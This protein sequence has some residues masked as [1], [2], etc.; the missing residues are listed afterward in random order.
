MT[1][2]ATN[3]RN[4]LLF[5]CNASE[6]S[7]SFSISSAVDAWIAKLYCVS[8][9]SFLWI[10]LLD[11]S[12]RMFFLDLTFT[13]SDWRCFSLSEYF[14]TF[15]RLNEWIGL[16]KVVR[17]TTNISSRGLLSAFSTERGRGMILDIILLNGPTILLMRKL[18]DSLDLNWSETSYSTS[19][20]TNEV[21]MW[22]NQT[23]CYA[24]LLANVVMLAIFGT[25][26]PS[27]RGCCTYATSYVQI[28]LKYVHARVIAYV[29]AYFTAYVS[30]YA[31]SSHRII[32]I[33]ATLQLTT[34]C[35]QSYLSYVSWR[36]RAVCRVESCWKD[37]TEL[38]LVIVL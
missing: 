4:L 11:W 14:G 10:L 33:S 30:A 18:K 28:K 25:L 22:R 6:A 19:A 29:I 5:F 20:I 21:E 36:F 13:P 34:L 23:E 12:A 27:V 24:M 1:G 16:A 7:C 31:S 8:F 26:Q 38:H 9:C 32:F 2:T 3:F 17:I 37:F 15:L 35:L